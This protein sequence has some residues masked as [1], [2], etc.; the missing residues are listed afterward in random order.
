MNLFCLPFAGG[1]KYS[2]NGFLKHTV[3]GLH[4][5]P[6]ELPGRGSRYG[7]GLQTAIDLLIKDIFAC[8][9]ERIDEPYAIYGH[10]MGSLLGYLLTLE[11]IKHKLNQP[12]HLFF[13][14]CAG[15]SVKRN[16]L[17]RYLLPKD[18]FIDMLRKMD[19]GTD[20]LLSSPEVMSV[21]EPILR[22]DFQAVETYEHQPSETL[23]IPIWVAIGT[24]E[25]IT[26]ENAMAWQKE[27]T[28]KVEV[29][30]LA[31]KHFFI[32]DH[33]KEIIKSIAGKLFE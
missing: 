16:G 13:T 10:S 4:I 33:E 17:K 30:Q 32:F 27:T 18:E 6:L 1:S 25:E 15:P 14:G 3:P 11:I 29:V 28:E 21:F 5:I 8:I 2:F 22:A 9:K 31:G 24:E 19:A 23:N 7:E 20:E 26:Y 12:V